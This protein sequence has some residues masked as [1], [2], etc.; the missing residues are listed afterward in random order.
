MS[1]YGHL[2]PSPSPSPEERRWNERLNWVA[3]VWGLAL[4]AL[5]AVCAYAI[6]M[7]TL[8]P[9]ENERAKAKV[10]PPITILQAGYTV[11]EE[12][13]G[14]PFQEPPMAILRLWKGSETVTLRD[15]LEQT[16]QAFREGEV[17]HPP[18]TVPVEALRLVNP[19]ARQT[20]LGVRVGNTAYKTALGKPRNS[21]YYRPN[22]RV[23]CAAF[24]SAMFKANGVRG[25]SFA[26]NTLYPQ[27]R[28]RGG[29]VVVSRMPTRYSREI[30]YL[31]AGDILFFHHRR[32]SRLAHTEVYVGR[33]LTAG[34]SSSVGRVAVRKVGNRGFT[35]VTAIRV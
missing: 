30:N 25:L 9:K 7:A 31:K 4:A 27:L 15:L 10:E 32:G 3:I 6:L 18:I 35:Q 13:D 14:S 2:P 5:F 23:A 28:K 19:K 21:K 8:P 34:T 20:I 24:V 26:V 12:T 33:G 22:P 1:D 11:G 16:P 29:K 17:P